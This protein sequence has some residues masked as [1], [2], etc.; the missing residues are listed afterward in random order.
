M[1]ARDLGTAGSAER[2]RERAG[3]ASRRVEAP[4]RLHAPQE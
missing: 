1:S 2:A 4:A 3:A